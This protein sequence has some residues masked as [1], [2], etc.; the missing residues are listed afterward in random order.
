VL[1]LHWR[2]GEITEEPFLSGFLRTGRVDVVEDGQEGNIFISDD[3]NGV[4]WRVTPS[5]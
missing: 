2:N 5:S 1:A 3:Y 4:I